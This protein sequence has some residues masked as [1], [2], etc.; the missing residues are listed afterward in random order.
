MSSSASNTR[1]AKN[2]IFLYFRSIIVLLVSIYTSR[3]ILDALGVEDYG[4]YNVVGGVVGMF[5]MIS[6][7]LQ[8]AS[9]R[10]ITFT[11]G[12]N[13]KEQLKKVFRTSVTLHIILGLILIIVLEIV[14][15]WLIDNQ[16]RIPV[17]RTTDAK[18]VFQFSLLT[19]FFNIISVPYSAVIIAHERMTVFAYISMIEA[20]LKLGVAFLIT[21][22]GFD[23]LL[24]FAFLHFFVAVLIRIIYTI[25]TYCNFE[26]TKSVKLKVDNS[27]FKEMFAYSSWNFIGSSALVLRNQGVD[28]LLNIFFGVVVNAAKAVSL[29]VQSAVEI[30]MG[31]FTTAINPQL[32]SSIAQKNY[33]RTSNLILH[34][35]RLSFFM[36]AFIAVPIIV[37]AEKILSIWLVSTPYLAVEFVQLSMILVLCNTMSRLVKNGILAKGDI[38]VFQIAV[39]SVKLLVLPLSYAILLIYKNPLVSYIVCIVVDF[40]CLGAE[41]YFAKKNIHINP[42]Q[43]LLK[44]FFPCW[45]LFVVVLILTYMFSRYIAENILLV[46][47]VSMI[48][49][50]GIIY[51]FS[52]S[53]ERDMIINPIKN[54]ILKKRNVP[55]N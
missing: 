22:S 28:I 27:I 12:L 52:T 51:L 32:T 19:L 5:S 34:G 33:Q 7:T 15:L 11:L 38:K 6:S 47:P 10:F 46:V 25:Y 2:T 14:G 55:K 41:L 21:M 16:L 29:Q 35:T 44:V 53:K 9:Q 4:V 50:F 18:I 26:E 37:C 23:K 13:D 31:N 24:L 54:R 39:G 36:M 45:I 43:F 48:I 20:G 1:I 30:L 42:I 49:S 40:I 3:V 17:A 8:A